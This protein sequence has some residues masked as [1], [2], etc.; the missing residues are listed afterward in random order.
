MHAYTGDDAGD[1][2]SPVGYM[3]SSVAFSNGQPRDQ[4]TSRT[5]L[6][7]VLANRDNT[8]CPDNCF[9]PVGLAL[10]AQGRLFVASD[11]TGELYV[12]DRS[13]DANTGTL[14]G[15]NGNTT[16]S[17]AGGGGS[18]AAA[19]AP[20]A[21]AYLAGWGVLATLV[22]CVVTGLGAVPLV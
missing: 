20:G 18:S 8:K 22:A 17:P 13:G 14:V 2:N 5:A 6:Q 21:A 16:K 9:R 3:V 4:T 1:R 7:A 15:G 11:T 19:R 12:L 10:D